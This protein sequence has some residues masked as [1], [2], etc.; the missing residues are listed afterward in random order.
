MELWRR[1]PLGQVRTARSV[2][3]E[4]ETEGSRLRPGTDLSILIPQ[5]EASASSVA[6]PEHMRRVETEHS[7]RSAL[8][9]R[10]DG[11]LLAVTGWDGE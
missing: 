7:G 11:K 8:A 3:F 10:D 6:A 1:S 5:T 9:L 4:G 2:P